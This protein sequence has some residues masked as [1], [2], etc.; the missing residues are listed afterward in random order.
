[1]REAVQLGRRG[2]I[3]VGFSLPTQEELCIFLPASSAAILVFR[4]KWQNSTAP[5]E[6]KRRI[7]WHDNAPAEVLAESAIKQSRP[8]NCD[9]IEYRRQRKRNKISG[10]DD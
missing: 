3:I 1:M 5:T 2:Q 8:I 7:A 10:A 9:T 6:R 4:I